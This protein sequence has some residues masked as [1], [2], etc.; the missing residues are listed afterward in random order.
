MIYNACKI[1]I[2]QM[3]M[4]TKLLTSGVTVTVF[5]VILSRMQEELQFYLITT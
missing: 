3:K 2:L 1:P 5:S 4:N